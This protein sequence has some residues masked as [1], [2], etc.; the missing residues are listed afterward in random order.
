MHNRWV[1]FGSIIGFFSVAL[2][3]FGAHGLR[4][5]LSEKALATFQLATQYQFLHALALLGLGVWGALHPQVDTTLAGWGFTLG[6]LIFSGSLYVLAV[7][8]IGIFGAITPIG[9]VAFLVGWAS[10]GAAV[11]KVLKT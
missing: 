6:C 1:L 5:R 3:A 4:D 9:G 7:T 2:G 11:L 10:F 8:G